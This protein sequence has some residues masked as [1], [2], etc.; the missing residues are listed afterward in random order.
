M[1]PI[2]LLF[3]HKT[4]LIATTALIFTVLVGA[5]VGASEWVSWVT[6]TGS[7][8]TTQEVL[9]MTSAVAHRSLAAY[10]VWARCQHRASTEGLISPYYCATEVFTSLLSSAVALA[11]LGQI[12]G[13]WKRDEAGTA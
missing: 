11:G 12:F 13:W 4:I 5:D 9:L 1:S 3:T 10:Q 2:R 7:S 8:S 6:S